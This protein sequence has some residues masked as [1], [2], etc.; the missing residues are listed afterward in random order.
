MRGMQRFSAPLLPAAHGGHYVVVP[1][2]VAEAAGIKHH[3]RVRGTCNGV[4]Y[5]SS[6]PINSG[7]Y[8]LG[9]HKA[10]LAE[11]GAAPGDE[12]TIAIELDPE[13][14]P[15]DVLPDDLAAALAR[16]ARAAAAWQALRPSHKR[17]HVKG[18]LEAKKLTTRAKRVSKAIAML[19]AAKKP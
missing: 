10:M 5:R 12:V 3:S 1:P 8:Y 18:I 13:P 14:L 4:A 11:A 7:V 16:D 6:T 9:L 2:A 17:E 15:T 19:R